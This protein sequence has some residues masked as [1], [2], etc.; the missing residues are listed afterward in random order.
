MKKQARARFFYPRQPTTGEWLTL[1]QSASH[2]ARVLRIGA[3][4][5]VELFGD[6]GWCAQAIVERVELGQITA[7]VQVVQEHVN[8]GPKLHLIQ[9][10]P[11][12]KKLDSIVRMVTELGVLE[13]QLASSERS[14]VRATD[15][16][17]GERVER[18]ERI[19]EEASRQSG[20]GHGS[21]RPRSRS[22][23]GGGVARARRT[24]S[25]AFLGR[26]PRFARPSGVTP[27]RRVGDCRPGGW[28]RQKRGAASC[29]MRLAN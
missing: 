20:R 3:G 10:V 9:V 12:G 24:P 19:A 17:W 16:K 2:H 8:R 27:H 25:I 18:L 5:T 22:P 14:I 11:K 28:P 15:S 1:D 13:V 26:A 7:S 21:S 4:D 6:D 29:E 23:T